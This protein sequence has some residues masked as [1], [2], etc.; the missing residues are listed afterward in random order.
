MEILPVDTKWIERFKTVVTEISHCYLM[1]KMMR[2]I[3]RVVA[4]GIPNKRWI[5]VTQGRVIGN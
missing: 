3:P 5:Y 4:L 1:H 2:A